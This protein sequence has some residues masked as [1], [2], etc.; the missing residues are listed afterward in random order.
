MEVQKDDL[1]AFRVGSSIAL[2]LAPASPG[3]KWIEQT[4]KSFAAHCLPMMMANQAG[5]V[6]LN[7][8]PVR[9]KWIG[10]PSTK[11]VIVECPGDPPYAAHSQF[12]YG[13]LTFTIPFLFRTSRGTAL[14]MRG[15]ANDP[16]DAIAPLEGLV[17]T[18]WAVATATMN[19]KF[20]RPNT[21]VDF[22]RDEPICMVV[23]QRMDLLEDARPQIRN[24]T[25]DQET[26]D[27][28]AAWARSR[29]QFNVNLAKGDPESVRKGWQRDYFR[30][31]AP[32]INSAPPLVAPQ[33]RTR[34]NLRKFCEVG[35]GRHS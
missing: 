4:T 27:G 21:W 5:W 2:E 32:P 6:V 19:W 9:A 13:I 11:S 20:T 26:L 3:R 7:D 1:I 18:D 12:G 29:H 22:A 33:H 28:Y 14:L 8:R 35:P 15:P 30:G 16:K 25:D 34:L 17:E 31:T 24:L 23:P 10:G